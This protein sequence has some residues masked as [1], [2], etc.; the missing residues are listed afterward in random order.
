[1]NLLRPLGSTTAKI[2]MAFLVAQIVAVGVA[3]VLMYGFTERTIT[4][5]AQN[6]VSELDSDVS[7]EF[8]RGGLAAATVAIEDRLANDGPRNAVIIL[9]A[10]NGSLAVGNLDAWPTG[11]GDSVGWQERVIRTTGSAQAAMSGLHTAKLAG[12]YVLLSGQI[13]ESEERLGTI[14]ESS[15]ITASLAGLVV[16]GFSAWLFAWFIGRRVNHIANVASEFSAGELAARVSPDG[17]GDAFDRL[18]HAINAMLERVQVLLTE[19]RLVTDALAHDLRS[20]IARLK[21]TID[22][23][24]MTTRDGTAIAALGSVSDEAD[25]LLRMLTTALQISRN[26]AG[27]GRE[28]F[29]RFD[30]AEMLRDLAEVYGPLAEDQGF[31]LE[32]AVPAHATIDAHRELLGQSLANLIDN[33]LKYAVG[34]STIA[35]SLVQRE[36]ALELAVADDGPGIAEDD[37]ALALRRFGRLEAAR[38]Q[39]GAGLGLSLVATVA[40][41]HGGT[42]AL[43]DNAP[44]LRA[45]MRLP[46]VTPQTPPVVALPQ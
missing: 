31:A 28:Q 36:G 25:R 41:L 15:L 39:G 26:E 40:H 11:L 43:E 18:G 37:R 21:A 24:S 8:E 6:F 27:I 45:V 44:G 7:D 22:R 10:P 9:R 4:A 13:L 33:A 20:P 12:G 17:S 42:F 2:A 16:A 30:G 19:L 3:L 32:V 29:T 5:D 1:M 46:S 34:G 35:L 14:I 23:A 38:P